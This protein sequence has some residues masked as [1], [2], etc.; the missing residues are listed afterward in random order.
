MTGHTP[1]TPGATRRLASGTL[2][3]FL[4]HGATDQDGLLTLGWHG[5]YEPMI[6]TYSGPASPYWAS[7]GFLG[8]LM[9]PDHPVWT[10]DEEPLPAETHDAATAL[11]PTGMLLQSTAADGLVR[12]HNHGSN[13][14]GDNEDP[15]YA[16][17]AY[18]T[19]TGP[20]SG[21]SERDNHF[22]LILDGVP[23]RRLTADPLGSA[24]DRAVSAHTPH[25]GIRIVSA[26]LVH[27][28][29]EVRAHLVTGAPE[30]TPVRQTG[31]A[32]HTEAVTTQLHPVH[33]YA[34]EV[35]QLPGGS[36]LFGNTSEILA[37]EGA[38]TGPASL[39]VALA[40]LTGEADPAPVAT[41]ADI[42]VQSPHVI[43]VTWQDGTAAVLHIPEESEES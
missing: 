14:V 43:H 27:G 26:T 42:R 8:L 28:R 18:S 7:K 23:T 22:A 37:V 4:D 39:F 30:P 6:Q 25:P 41:L 15:G 5:R 16:R 11:G 38:T 21:D 35:R 31:W 17:F 2:R 24:P 29:A 13:H 19:R 3:Y 34:P 33:G 40:S 20:T 36:T 32:R 1:L 10:A 9:P 12:L